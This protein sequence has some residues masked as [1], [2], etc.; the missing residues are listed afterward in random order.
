MRQ[1][2]SPRIKAL[3]LAVLFF[4]I[5]RPWPFLFGSNNFVTVYGGPFGRSWR[6]EYEDLLRMICNPWFLA[7]LPRVRMPRR[8]WS[9]YGRKVR[10]GGRRV[11]VEIRNGLWEVSVLGHW[12]RLGRM[13]PDLENAHYVQNFRMSKVFFWKFVSDY[14]IIFRKVVPK[15]IRDAIPPPKCMAMLLYWLARGSS[16]RDVGTQFHVSPAVVHK[17]IHNGVKGLRERLVPRAIRFPEGMELLQVM[18]D[19]KNLGGLPCVAGAMDGTFFHILKPS[20]NGDAYWCYKG[21]PAISVLAVVDARMIFTYV[22]SGLHGSVGDAGAFMTSELSSRLQHGQVLGPDP[23]PHVDESG[24]LV[25]YPVTQVVQGITIAPYLVADSAFALSNKVMKCYDDK[26]GLS[27][28]QD[29]F[30]YCVIRTRRVVENA[31]ARLKGRWQVVVN[32]HIYDPEFASSVC[33]VVCAL[34]NVVETRNCGFREEWLQVEEDL[35]DRVPDYVTV[36]GRNMYGNG[37]L[38]HRLPMFPLRS[39]ECEKRWRS[40]VICILNVLYAYICNHKRY[41]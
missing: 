20:Y 24:A 29:D 14:D 21:F 8:L 5:L 39:C 10:V 31:F 34:H 33:Q 7:A 13:Y 1:P 17:I 6:H 18:H 19:F 15:R 2:L 16:F 30:N 23:V 41:S 22:R 12:L 3:V 40:N 25:Y 27:A 37:Q 9:Q 35:R 26:D 4:Q 32:N 38:L 36:C 28:V 11:T